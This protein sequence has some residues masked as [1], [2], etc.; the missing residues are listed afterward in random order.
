VDILK[1]PGLN[2][3]N[4]IFAVPEPRA[5]WI[6]TTYWAFILMVRQRRESVYDGLPRW[7][8]DHEHRAF[9]S[10]SPNFHEHANCGVKIMLRRSFGPC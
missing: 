2:G 4:G 5:E 6:A 7:D 9:I 1:A 10:R 3:G 8:G